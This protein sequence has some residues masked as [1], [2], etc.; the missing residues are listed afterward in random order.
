MKL[1]FKA[2]SAGLAALLAVCAVPSPASAGTECRGSGLWNNVFP[3]TSIYTTLKGNLI[4]SRSDG[5]WTAWAGI[6]QCGIGGQGFTSWDSG[7]TFSDRY[8]SK[9]C[10]PGG[11]GPCQNFDWNQLDTWN[12][13]VTE[14]GVITIQNFTWG[15]TSTIYGTCTNT[16]GQIFGVSGNT[17][18]IVTLAPPA[19]ADPNCIVTG[20]AGP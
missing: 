1:T 10:Q 13:S 7:I 12:V 5:A 8:N 14:D 15:G 16:N 18:V 17:S 9:D 19:P 20:R 6:G 2:A 3:V 11:L 4:V